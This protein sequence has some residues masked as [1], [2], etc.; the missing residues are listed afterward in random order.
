M[1]RV[2]CIGHAVQDYV[3]HVP[4]LPQRAEKYRADAFTC[5]GGGPAATAAVAVA[6]LGGAAQL[7][8]RVGADPIADAIEHELRSYGVDC[9]YLRRIDGC[10]SSISAVFI[11]AQ[12]ERMI[13]NHVDTKLARDPMWL[14]EIDV[15]TA[16]AVLADTRWPEGAAELLGRARRAGKIAVLDADVPVPQAWEFL[17]AATHIAFSRPGLR[18]FSGHDEIERALREV[19]A[20]TGAWCCVTLGGEGVVYAANG[21]LA[22]EPAFA[23]QPRDTLGAGDVWHGA[24]ALALAEG[25]REPEAVRA[26]SAAA[27]IKVGRVGG[28]AAIPTRAERD[29]LL[30]AT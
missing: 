11:D 4:Q 24:L 25:M 23:V 1:K 22:R 28:R 2:L 26:A 19:A 9:R 6:R 15:T 18:D 17:A 30:G 5:A 7:V 20:R 10:S 3:F 12:G 27:A 21:E 14:G 8:A 16:D 13:V 29:R